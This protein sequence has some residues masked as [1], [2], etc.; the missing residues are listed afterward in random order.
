[1]DE[2][3]ESFVFCSLRSPGN[4]DESLFAMVKKLRES[5]LQT[6]PFQRGYVWPES[7]LKEW[8]QTVISNQAIGII[9]TYQIN[10]GGPEWL[11]DGLQRLTSTKMFLDNPQRYGFEFSKE[12]AEEYCEKYGI[13][14]QHRHYKDHEAAMY[15]YKNLNRGTYITPAEYHKGDMTIN[16]IGDYAYN[17]IIASLKKIECSLMSGRSPGRNPES[18]LARDSLG[19][20]YQYISGF[21]G[22]EFWNVGQINQNGKAIE[23]LLLECMQGWD[24]KDVDNRLKDF[25]LFMFGEVAQL[26]DIMRK[27]GCEG[28]SFSPAALRWIFHLSLWRKNNN[29]S[30]NLHVEFLEKF[31]ILPRS[32]KTISSR[33]IL[34]A[35]DDL[36]SVTLSMDGL[37]QLKIMCEYMKCNLH[38]PE[39]R[40]SDKITSIGYHNSHVKPF[41]IF[42]NGETFSEPA[43]LNISRGA[44]PV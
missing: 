29:R 9:V 30:C 12:Q 25:E 28:I 24:E 38:S 32:T 22:I 2:K 4:R 44:N 17:A 14:I 8:I 23:R 40:S 19:L 36:K 35:G 18:K 27:A 21:P 37:G 33:I 13:S 7:K 1:M 43:P 41:S 26:R 5:K 6:P 34:S 20:F 10:G 31:F 3:D 39:K 16:D 15:A 42:G 11:A